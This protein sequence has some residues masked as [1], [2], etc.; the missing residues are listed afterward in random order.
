MKIALAARY[1]AWML[2]LLPSTLG[3]GSMVLWLRSLHWPLSID[4]TGLT[5]RNHRRVD[6]DSISRIGV[7]RSYLDGHISEIRVHHDTGVSKIPVRALSDGD[8][9]ARTILTLFAQASRAQARD[10][11]ARD[12][13]A[14]EGWLPRKAIDRN[15][16][17]AR[18]DSRL[19]WVT[20]FPTKRAS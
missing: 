2:A 20:Q 5:L 1:R 13:R 9:V 3:L 6:W 11:R 17:S 12:E 15:P 18:L 10:N 4:A 8:R 14:G 7:S 19:R 16:Y